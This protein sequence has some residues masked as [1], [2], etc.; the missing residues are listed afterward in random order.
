MTEPA[1]PRKAT[2]RDLESQENYFT[3]DR[4]PERDAESDKMDREKHLSL[5][6]MLQP[7]RDTL[8]GWIDGTAI[9]RRADDDSDKTSQ[10][11]AGFAWSLYQH[12]LEL[13][14]LL[15]LPTLANV[16]TLTPSHDKQAEKSIKK[17]LGRL[18]LWG[19]GFSG[20]KLESVLD[21]SESLRETVVESLTAIGTILISS[22]S[23]A[24]RY[25]LIL[26]T[27]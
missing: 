26:G 13:F 10:E 24:L 17:S 6:N 15:L 1:K 23:P 19:G 8:A 4:V 9:Q 25:A 3:V 27:N 11:H 12:T 2:V 21:E 18:F 5:N 7:E 14:S 16:A 20:G 22:K